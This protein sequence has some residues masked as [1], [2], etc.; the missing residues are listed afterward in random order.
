MPSLTDPPQP[1]PLEHLLLQGSIWRGDSGASESAATVDTGHAALNDA[2]SGQGWPLSSLIEVCQRNFSHNE[3]LLLT[4]ALL[5]MTGGY[6]VLLNP[7][8]LPFAQGLIQAGINLEQILVVETDNKADFL[9]SFT[10][11]A[12]AHACDALLAWQP[13]QTLSYTELRKCLLAAADGQALCVIFRSAKSRQQSSPA[14]LRLYT[15]IHAEALHIDIFKQKGSLQTAQAPSIRLA[16]P[17]AWHRLPA[18][19]LLGEDAPGVRQT[20]VAT[21]RRSKG[22]AHK[23]IPLHR[24]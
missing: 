20:T 1:A 22:A 11:L 23:I 21:G 6:L 19:R 15:E 16:L 3:W 18:H 8:A 5:K 7:P 13:Q 12:R 10:T 9:Y 14:R 17:E 4:P 24:R 2:L